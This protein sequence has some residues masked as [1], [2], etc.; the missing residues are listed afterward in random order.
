MRTAGVV[1][2]KSIFRALC[3]LGVAVTG[4]ALPAAA[5]DCSHARISGPQITKTAAP[6]TSDMNSTIKQGRDLAL[7]AL[8]SIGV[9]PVVVSPE[10][11]KRVLEQLR[12]GSLDLVHTI[13]KSEE[14]SKVYTFTVP[15][16]RDVHGILVRAGHSFPYASVGDLDGKIGAALLGARLP[17]PLNKIRERDIGLI[18]TSSPTSLFDMLKAGRVDF[19]VGPIEYLLRLPQTAGAYRHKDFE[20]LSGA[21]VHIPVHMAFSRKS[22]CAAKL[23]Q[24]NAALQKLSPIRLDSRVLTE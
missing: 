22:P 7:R 24:L 6:A 21:T 4:V 19:I 16:K 13:L 17:P 14:R 1:H 3:V 2:V 11:W 18:E 8:T 15:W 12:S 10:P 20:I 5:A 23:E 9:E